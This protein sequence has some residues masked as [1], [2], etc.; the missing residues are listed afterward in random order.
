[1]DLRHFCE[2][3]VNQDI[4]DTSCRACAGGWS[5]KGSP[6]KYRVKQLS[7]N[8]TMEKIQADGQV[9]MQELL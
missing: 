9:R 4:D 1:M 2:I 7:L 5:G 3:C 6:P 8:G